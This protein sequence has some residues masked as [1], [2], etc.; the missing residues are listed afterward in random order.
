MIFGKKKKPE[1]REII[2]KRELIRL[3]ELNGKADLA[4][5]YRDDLAVMLRN[6]GAGK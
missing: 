5:K 1:S 6:A 3:A 2:E 4:K